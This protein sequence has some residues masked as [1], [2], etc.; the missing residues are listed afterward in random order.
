MQI[1]SITL[2]VNVRAAE[3]IPLEGRATPGPYPQIDTQL[4]SGGARERGVLSSPL[5]SRRKVITG[6]CA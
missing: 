5:L 3:A 2:H 6:F 4:R 1:Q